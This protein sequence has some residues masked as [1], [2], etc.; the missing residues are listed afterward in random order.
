M[1]SI[2]PHGTNKI[3]L[4]PRPSVPTIQKCH[5]HKIVSLLVGPKGAKGAAHLEW[6]YSTFHLWLKE[7]LHPSF[8][9]WCFSRLPVTH[10]MTAGTWD[11]WT[12]LWCKPDHRTKHRF[13][14]RPKKG[15]VY[16]NLVTSLLSN[17][18][19]DFCFDCTDNPTAD[20]CVYLY[21]CILEREG[22]RVLSA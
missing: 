22:E 12:H 5:D 21:T 8:H 3:C 17:P 1:A 16:S 7:V 19:A 13:V 18:A 9:Y 10:W 20:K 14:S 11:M 6:C 4:M 15:S 2:G